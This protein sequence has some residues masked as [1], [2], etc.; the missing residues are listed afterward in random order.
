MDAD[1]PYRII[2]LICNKFQAGNI[3]PD[4]YMDAINQ[5]QTSF[6]SYL[7]GQF[8]SYQYGRPLSKVQ[9]GMNEI[10]RQRIT[11]LI[12]PPTTITIDDTGLAPYPSDFEQVDALNLTSLDRIR[13]VPQHKKYSY[14]K[15][16]I[17]PIATNPIFMIE[18]DGFRFYPNTNFNGISLGTVQL[19]YVKTPPQIVWGSAPDAQGR[20]QYDAGASKP[21]IWYSVDGMELISRALA[22]FGVNLQASE[23]SQ[24][25]QMI[26]TQ[27]D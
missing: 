7:L 4:Q 22:M 9:F 21:P 5:G 18:S 11:P 13:F 26:K 12:D 20:P 8:V 1:Q 25:A 17:D 15:S 3:T 19:G 16:R 14:I 24:Y 10:V 2:Q 6:L 23:V 27:G